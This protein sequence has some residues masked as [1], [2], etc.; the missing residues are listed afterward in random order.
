MIEVDVGIFSHNEE[1]AVTGMLTSLASQDIFQH[2]EF[3]TKV[4][5]LANGCTD[6]T[7]AKAK[8]YMQSFPGKLPLQ[9]VETD[10]GGKSRTWN[11]FVHDTS[12]K[13]AKYTVFCDCDIELPRTDTIRKMVEFLQEKPEVDAASS[14]PVKDITFYP[15]NLTFI[16]KIISAS[17]D[18]LD[19]GQTSICGQL[20][21]MRTSTARRIHIPIGLPVEDGFVRAMILTDRLLKSENFDLIGGSNSIFHLYE[22]ERKVINLVRH[23]VRIVIG[24][25]INSAIFGYLREFEGESKLRE[26]ERSSVDENWVKNVCETRLPNWRFGWVPTHFLFKRLVNAGRLGVRTTP[27]R[28]ILTVIGFCFDAVVYVI[29]QVK[30]ARGKNAG[31]W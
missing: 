2:A 6:Q 5:L 16:E 1:I 22:S 3:S 25:A 12:R 23:Q 26:L 30:M 24:S 13:S 28:L 11:L 17:G 20:Y 9:I 14:R 18:Q 10:Q 4:F 31:Y 8:S 15:K 7:V 19:G 27:K 29:A 21:I